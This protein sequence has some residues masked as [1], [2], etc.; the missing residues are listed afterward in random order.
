MQLRQ[1]ELLIHVAQGTTHE[2]Q[3]FTALKYADGHVD[4]QDPFKKYP[5]FIKFF[6]TINKL[7]L[8][9]QTI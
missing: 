9:F 6:E 1:L 2:E 4:K 3:I 7:M 8:S 5:G